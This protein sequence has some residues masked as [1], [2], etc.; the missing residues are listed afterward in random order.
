MNTNSTLDAV[1]IERTKPVSL[2]LLALTPL[3]LGTVLGVATNYLNVDVSPEYFEMVMGWDAL[4]KSYITY[5]AVRQGALEGAAYGG[6]F[7]FI[8]TIYVARKNYGRLEYKF[9]RFIFIRVPIIVLASWLVGGVLG[10]VVFRMFPEFG[11]GFN[12]VLTFGETYLRERF[13]WA[14]GS[15]WGGMIGGVLALGWAIYSTSREG[16]KLT[17]SS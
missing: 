3:L 16:N 1:L 12:N 9:F 10:V 2:L 11:P 4:S 15:I 17:T 13:G 6:I 8:F 14:G 5:L 7:S